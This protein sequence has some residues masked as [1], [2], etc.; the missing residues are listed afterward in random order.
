[1][2]FNFCYVEAVRSSSV[3][4]SEKTTSEVSQHTKSGSLY[5]FHNVSSTLAPKTKPSVLGISFTMKKKDTINK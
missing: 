4:T 1:M 2:K 3:G 5:I